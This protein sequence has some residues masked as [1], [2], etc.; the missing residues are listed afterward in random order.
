V[1]LRGDVIQAAVTSKGVVETPALV[2]AA[3]AWFRRVG[4]MVGVD[5]P[6]TPIA[7]RSC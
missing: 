1:R 2:C 3:G 7:A 5:L 6:V 4:A